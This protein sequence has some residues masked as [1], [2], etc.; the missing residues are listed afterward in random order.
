[1][2]IIES[3]IHFLEQLADQ[4]PVE[5]FAFFGSFIEELIAPIPSPVVMTLAGTMVASNGSPFW[6]L[7]VVAVIA[8]VGKTIGAIILYFLADKTE[9]VVLS[10]VG[11]YIGVTHKQVDSIGSRFKGTPRDYLTL[12]IIRS[13][14][15]IPSA[16]ISLI[17]GLIA[18]PKKLFI[19]C[20]FFGTIIRDFIYLYIGFTGLSAAAEI[21]NGIEGM[22]SIVTILL[23][24]VGAGIFGWILYKKYLAPKKSKETSESE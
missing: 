3:L 7:F 19:I 4:V 11:R 5:L 23:G 2:G 24:I 15:I 13:T 8:A 18:L 17:C 12:L 16:P 20:S 1:M 6:Y 10:R 9:D 22:N 21:T 14:P